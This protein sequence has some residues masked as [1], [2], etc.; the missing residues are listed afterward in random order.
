[1]LVDIAR[2]G[3]MHPNTVA[4]VKRAVVVNGERED[5][6]EVPYWGIA[7]LYVSFF[8]AAVGISLVSR[9]RHPISHYMAPRLR[10]VHHCSGPR[11]NC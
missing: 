11:N 10:A 3:L 2:R 7:L 1:M 9:S 5:G 8:G 4:Y 6:P